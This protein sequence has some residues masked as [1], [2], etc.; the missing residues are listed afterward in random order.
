MKKTKLTRSLLAACSIVALSA[1][2]YGC[3][4]DGGDEEAAAPPVVVDPPEPT[5]EPHACDDGAS[6]AC[7]DARQAELDAIEADDDA[8]VAQLN[9]ARMA[10]SDAQDELTAANTAAEEASTVSGLIDTAVTAADGI[11]V[12]STPNAVKA[13]REAIDAAQDS[14]DEMENLTDAA[15]TALQGRIDALERSFGPNEMAANA[16][17]ATAAAKTKATAIGKVVPNATMPDTPDISVTAT[18][19]G[20]KIE[21]EGDDDFDHVMGPMYRLERAADEDGNVVEEIV[22]V[23]HTIVEPKGMGFASVH[24]LNVRADG[25]TVDAANPADSLDLGGDLVSTDAAQAMVLGRVNSADFAAGPRALSD[26][27]GS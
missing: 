14:L 8:T 19:T 26:Q 18:R 3:V 6:Q 2:M 12:E 23:N 5:P 10:L 21:V 15:E 9:A 17:A 11:D 22:L 13:A 4:H 16:A 1:V 27:L 20:P 25:V 7:V 24:T